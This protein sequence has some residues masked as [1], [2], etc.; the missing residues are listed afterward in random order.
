MKQFLL[1]TSA[2]FVLFL[3]GK[4][5]THVVQV[6]N[7]QFSPQTITN[8]LVGDVIRWEFVSG[9]H[10]TTCNPTTTEGTSLPAG[11]A[12][13]DA[14]ITS[15]APSFEY[16][17]TVAGTYNYLCK[18]HAP[19]M[20]GSFTAAAALPVKLKNFL[21][22]DASGNAFLKWTTASEENVD[23]FSVTRSAN[24]SSFTEIAKIPA[25]GNSSSEKFY[26]FTDTKLNPSQ[27]YYYYQIAIVDKD[28]KRNFTDTKIFRNNKAISK[29]IL[30]MSPNPISRPGH[31]MM[32]FNAEKE[33]KMDVKVVNNEGKTLINTTM[34]AY[35]GVNNGHIHLGDLPTGTY[36]IICTINGIKESK[37]LLYR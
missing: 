8:V 25:A 26:S 23:Y 5:A 32:S 34:Q 15:T 2:V 7:F 20:A 13:W 18:P 36:T 35:V 37:S 24:G 6:S 22:E 29:I 33:G 19:Q 21:L 17:V 14:P 28:G 11:A 10:T 3:S 12:T 9:F 16:T 31:L 27:K 4:A 1:L 30:S